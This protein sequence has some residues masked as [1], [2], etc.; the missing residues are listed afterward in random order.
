MGKEHDH[1]SGKTLAHDFPSSSLAAVATRSRSNP[2][3]SCSAFSGAEA[4]KV[5]M[6]MTRPELPTLRSHPNVDACSTATRAVTDGGRTLARY[7]GVCRSKISPDGVD[8]T[9][10]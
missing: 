6:P 1:R 3:F 8:T 9:A 5:F 7:Y 4:P 10:E 2:N